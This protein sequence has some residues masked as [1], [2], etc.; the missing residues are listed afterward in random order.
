MISLLKN[1]FLGA[2]IVPLFAM[3]D[4]GRIDLEHEAAPHES[5]VLFYDWKKDEQYGYKI[6]RIVQ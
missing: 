3:G 2:L 1:A 6:N 4:V 5:Q